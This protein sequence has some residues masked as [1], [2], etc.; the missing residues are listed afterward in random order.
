MTA[1]SRPKTEPDKRTAVLDAALVLFAEKGFHGT[2][3]P[4]IAERARVGAGTIYR[5]FASKEELVNAL[6]Q[7]W[8]LELANR[9]TA[10]IALDGTLREA[11]H[12][13]CVRLAEFA[14]EQP[15]AF[16]FLELHHHAPYLDKASL[17]VETNFLTTLGSLLQDGIDQGVLKPLPP[18][19]LFAMAWGALTGVLRVVALGYFKLNP[20]L[21]KQVEACVWGTLAR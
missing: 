20:A 2:A 7:H 14:E 12:V 5:Y 3:M 4:E 1:S 16:Q 17:S 21:L 11:F 9:L 15:S 10:D 18:E 8:K 19:C 6:F 13:V